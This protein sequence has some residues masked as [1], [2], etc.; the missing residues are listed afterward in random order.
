[1]SVALLQSRLLAEIAGIAH[2]FST[3]E[4]GVSVGPYA[5]LNVGAGVADPREAVDTNRRRILESL[6]R[7]QAQWVSVH[8]MHGS[9]VV[10]VTRNAGRAIEADGLVSRDP[11]AMLAVLVADCVPILAAA[12]SGK[13]VAAVHAGWRG[14]KSRIAQVMV[15]RFTDM[16]V[17]P[18]ALRVAIGPAIGPCCFAIGEDVAQELGAA[19]PE[20]ASAVQRSEGRTTADLWAFNRA[21]LIAAGV[22]EKAIDT[23]RI[24]V[25]CQKGF[26]SHRRDHGATGRQ[27]GVIACAR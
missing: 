8:Q 20:A 23:F 22:A 12:T 2:G 19:I 27:S 26:F 1:M 11:E 18:A 21:V 10:E 9:E 17:E 5:E 4:G 6:N 13:V 7:P 16:G 25:A 14:T 3:R 15:K 24:C